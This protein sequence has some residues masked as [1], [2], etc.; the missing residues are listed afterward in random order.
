MGVSCDEV[1]GTV[2][3]LV[4][5]LAEALVDRDTGVACV[6]SAD[7]NSVA[8][9]DSLV[10]SGVEAGSSSCSGFLTGEILADLISPSFGVFFFFRPFWNVQWV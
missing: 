9:A 10:D 5:F 7:F 2:L 8:D 3:A 1:A 4:L 6:A